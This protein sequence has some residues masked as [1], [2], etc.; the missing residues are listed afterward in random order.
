MG[1]AIDQEATAAADAFAAV[2][3]KAHGPLSAADQALV[4]LIDRFQQGQVG[5]DVLE[6]M[7]LKAARLTGRKLSPDAQGELHV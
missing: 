6:L 2:V 3:V 5:G 4:E 1:L 7:P